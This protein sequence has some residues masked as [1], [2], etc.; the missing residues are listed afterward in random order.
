[1]ITT[2][3]HMPFQTGW[4]RLQKIH[5]LCLTLG[6]LLYTALCAPGA[7]FSLRVN[8]EQLWLT[9]ENTP[10]QDLMRAFADRGVAIRLDPQIQANVNGSLEDVSVEDALTEILEPFSYVIFWKRMPSP[11]GEWIQPREIQIYLPGG[12]SRMKMVPPSRREIVHPIDGPSYVKEEI[13]L[14]FQEKLSKEE[15]RN[16]LAQIG[17]TVVEVIV[18]PGVYRIRLQENADVP[19]LQAL[20]EQNPAVYKAEPNYVYNPVG[21]APGLD[22]PPGLSPPKVAEGGPALAI[23]DSGLNPMAGLSEAVAAGLDATNPD[24]VLQDDSGHGTQMALIA[25]GS[26]VPDN[27]SAL[28]TG[29]PLV[30]IKTFDEN[31]YASSY[32]IM[33]ALQFATEKGAR[34]VNMS[35]GSSADSFFLSNA[36]REAHKAGMLLVAS[37]GNEPTGQPVYPAAYPEVISV[38]AL[39]HNGTPWE[40]SN[41]GPTV[42]LIA[43]GTATL[44]VGYKGDAGTYAG[45]SISAAYVSSLLSAYVRKNREK[46]NTEVIQAL[47]E[48]LSPFNDPGY[49]KGVLDQAA[50]NRFLGN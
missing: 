7:D 17:G 25:S 36:M 46:S 19:S 38:A 12:E 26:V 47:N 8:G 5:L 30:A 4:Q 42:D 1:M 40:L 49:G 23:L 10:I 37:P 14:G 21:E 22:L 48:S 9:C 43:P 18:P 32:D 50:V 11:S 33:T 34:V 29:S 3:K 15:F 28:E 45:T 20:L 44:P 27:G 2:S 41:Y 13:L 16:L 39:G 31:G 6:T 35:W 24:S